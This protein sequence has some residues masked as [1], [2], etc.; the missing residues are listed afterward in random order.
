MPTTLPRV[1][2]PFKRGTFEAIT[3]M[4]E[5]EE[6][7]RARIVADLVEAAIDLVED[8]ALGEIAAARLKDFRPDDAMTGDELLRWH[9]RRKTK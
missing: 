2:V 7:S 6:T 5:A 3:R 4:A 9:K 8:L 1:N